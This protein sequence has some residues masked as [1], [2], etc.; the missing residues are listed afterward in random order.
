MSSA[1]QAGGLPRDEQFRQAAL[2]IARGEVVAFP[3]ETY[4]GLAV[5][6]FNPTAIA[7]L[8]RLKGRDYSKPI[9]VL[10]ADIGQLS[11]LVSAIPDQYQPLIEAYWPGPLT[12]IFP[13]RPDLSPLLTGNTGTVGVRL[14][15]HP[16]ACRLIRTCRLPLTATSAN[17]AGL[18][19]AASA[20]A[21]FGYFGTD[22][23]EVLDGGETEGGPSS[24][25]VG[26]ENGALCLIRRGRITLPGIGDHRRMGIS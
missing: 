1:E 26:L 5:D 8:F 15:P 14:S 9:L 13:A 19:P 11:E 21:V 10:I 23:E 7:Q 24:T 18:P 25:V 3:T 4:Y 16:I 22:I 20:A 2:A 17:P 6:P 12:L